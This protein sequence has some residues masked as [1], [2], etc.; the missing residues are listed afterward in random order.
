MASDKIFEVGIVGYGFS[1]KVF[2][3]P[4]VI[5]TPGLQFAA[6]VQRSSGSTVWGKA[7]EDYPNLKIYESAD[8]LVADASIHVIVVSTPPWTHMAMAEMALKAGKHVILEKHMTPMA[9]E[10]DHLIAVAKEVN[11]QL[12]VFQSQLVGCC[13]L[14]HA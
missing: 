9:Q 4:F 1:A 7:S 6:I 11:R 2:Q 10:A 8:Q 5:T 3:I 13:L 12:I 14:F